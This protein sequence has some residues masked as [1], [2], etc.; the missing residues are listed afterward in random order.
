MRRE[1]DLGSDDARALE[2]LGYRW[3]TVKVAGGLWLIIHKFPVPAGYNVEAAQVAIRLDTYPPGIIDMAYFSPALAR[4]DGR[5]INNLTEFPLD[6]SNYQQ[7]SRHYS[8]TAGKDT[9]AT[10]LRKVRGWL[11]HEFRKR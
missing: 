1:F 5:P 8:W 11:K 7:W 4:T 9:L 2:A 6:G 10:H 3:E